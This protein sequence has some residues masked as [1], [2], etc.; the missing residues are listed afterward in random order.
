MVTDF[1]ARVLSKKMDL[2]CSTKQATMNLLVEVTPPR[3]WIILQKQYQIL[4]IFW[5]GDLNY[6][7]LEICSLYCLSLYIKSSKC[8]FALGLKLEP[9]SCS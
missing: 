8:A 6:H 7:V 5:K 3:N 9:L 4:I 2:K 1:S